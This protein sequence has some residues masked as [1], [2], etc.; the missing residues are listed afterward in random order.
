[1]SLESADEMIVACRSHETAGLD[2][3]D[4]VAGVIRQE[5][6]RCGRRLAEGIGHVA[7]RRRETSH[8]VFCGRGTYQTGLK[9][10]S[11]R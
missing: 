1:V 8:R 9:L 6:K 7:T 2:K 4:R 11:L 5:S 10:M 3:G